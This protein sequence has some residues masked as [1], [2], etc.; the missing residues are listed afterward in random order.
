M[1]G[2]REPFEA[3]CNEY[4]EKNVVKFLTVDTRNPSSILNSLQ[5]A[6]D[7][8][9]TITDVIPRE[10]ISEHRKWKPEHKSKKAKQSPH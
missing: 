4:S 5:Y 1:T 6:R 7:N 3:I 10:V 8:A 9:R 2:N